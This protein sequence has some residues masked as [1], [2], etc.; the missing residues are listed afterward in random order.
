[1]NHIKPNKDLVVIELLY[2]V[3][4]LM[5]PN[6]SMKFCKMF[7]QRHMMERFQFRGPTIL[8]HGIT[9]NRPIPVVI[10]VLH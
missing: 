4:S 1:M 9:L 6:V 8:Q 10:D 3:I 7:G 2:H 5:F